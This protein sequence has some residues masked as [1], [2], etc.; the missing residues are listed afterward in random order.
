MTESCDDDAPPLM[1]QVE[2]TPGPVADGEGTPHRH[3]ARAH[4]GMLPATPMVDTG[5]L[6]A[7]FLVT[8]QRPDGVD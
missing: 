4:K 7:E 2:T 8:S 3:Q 5:D 1:T 6:D